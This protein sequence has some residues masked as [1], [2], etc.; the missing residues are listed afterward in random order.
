MGGTTTTGGLFLFQLIDQIDQ[1][2]EAP[3]A[4]VRM[5]A[6]ATAMHRWVLPVPV[7]PMEIALRLVYFPA[8]NSTAL[9]FGEN[10][11]VG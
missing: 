4:R 7:P 10:R 2:E 6:E 5:A 8:Q 9:S 1:V 3:L 11:P